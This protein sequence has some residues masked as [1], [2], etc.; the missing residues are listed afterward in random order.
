MS[1]SLRKGPPSP[2]SLS[3]RWCL[4]RQPH[5]AKVVARLHPRT[6]RVVRSTRRIREELLQPATQPV[7]ER[8]AGN[9][10]EGIGIHRKSTLARRSWLRD[11]RYEFRRL[12]LGIENSEEQS[13]HA[14]VTP[15]SQVSRRPPQ[16]WRCPERRIQDRRTPLG[17][18]PRGLSPRATSGSSKGRTPFSK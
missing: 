11:S 17:A 14:D 12:A 10:G 2:R 16:P 9:G 5:K 6:C 1:S 3:A 4:E 8:R 18:P 15:V 7:R 13:R